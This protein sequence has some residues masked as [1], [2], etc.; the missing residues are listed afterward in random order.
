MFYARVRQVHPQSEAKAVE[1]PLSV[2]SLS[3]GGEKSP[4]FME[5]V[6]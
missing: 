2:D 6:S 4:E 1:D 3:A 5:R